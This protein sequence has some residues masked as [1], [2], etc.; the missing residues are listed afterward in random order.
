MIERFGDELGAAA[1]RVF[2]LERGPSDST[3]HWLL[4]RQTAHGF[5][6]ALVRQVKDALARKWIAND[7]LP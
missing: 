5:G 3:L 2:G 6:L 7:L 1:R 4:A